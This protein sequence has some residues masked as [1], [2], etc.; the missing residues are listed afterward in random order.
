MTCKNCNTIVLND[1]NFCGACGAKIIRNRLTLK[2]L[3]SDFVE[4]YLNYDNKFFQTF[5]NLFK[6][7]EDVIGTYVTGTRKKYVNVIS[8]FTIAITF[9]G[10]EYF[11]INRFFPNFLDLSDIS[12]KGMENFSNTILNTIQEYQSFVLMLFV[13]LYAFMA[14]MTFFN[15]KKFNY[16]EL[17]VI[18]MYIIAHT[19]ILGTL[20]IIPSAIF[21]LK[22]GLISPI[23][24]IFQILYSAFCLKRLYNLSFKGIILRTLFFLLI[25]FVIY[26]IFIFAVLGILLLTKGPEFFKGIIEAQKAVSIN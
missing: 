8:Y 18:F 24:L 25:L 3:L 17:I 4:T 10:L 12:Q 11:F 16:T 15:I 7:P 5:I 13:P 20:I 21:E 26:I 19:S 2:N 9:T 23:V 6:Q 14:K 1:H 22:M